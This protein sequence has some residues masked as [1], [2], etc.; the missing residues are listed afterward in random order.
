MESHGIQ[1][2]RS[3]MKD[4][5]KSVRAMRQNQVKMPKCAEQIPSGMLEHLLFFAGRQSGMPFL[6][7]HSITAC[8][9]VGSVVVHV[10]LSLVLFAF[11]H[12]SEIAIGFHVN[13][14]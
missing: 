7:F 11:S 6:S 12:F 8:Y 1:P 13:E 5:L 10:D 9:A 4:M 2:D 14:L 3:S